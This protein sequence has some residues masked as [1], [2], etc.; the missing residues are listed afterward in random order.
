MINLALTYDEHTKRWAINGGPA[1]RHS[2]LLLAL[3]KQVQNTPIKVTSTTNEKWGAP[4]APAKRAARVSKTYDIKN[5]KVVDITDEV[6]NAIL[7]D[8]KLRRQHEVFAQVDLD[9]EGLI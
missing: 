4:L 1:L 3:Y 8:K 9:L 2:D 5:G 7:A 6:I